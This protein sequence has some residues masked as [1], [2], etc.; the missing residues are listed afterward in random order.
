MPDTDPTDVSDDGERFEDTDN[1]NYPDVPPLAAPPPNFF[2]Q[3]VQLA[4][5]VS[6]STPLPLRTF[7]TGSTAFHLNRR[8]DL[9][10]L[11][12][13]EVAVKFRLPD[14]RAA[15]ADYIRHVQDLR[16]SMFKIGQRRLSR[17]N[18]ELPF[19]HLRVWYSTRVQVQS[20][21]STDV[22]V[23][24]RVCAEPP[25]LEWPFG[26]YDTVLLSDGSAPG[27]GLHGMLSFW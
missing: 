21:D 24:H 14:L 10:P 19:T 8:P 3:A 7:C 25:S 13:D 15:L 5:S 18:T 4:A 23:P 9:A 27:R 1:V 20:I 17:A 2:S 6:P 22:S 26:R 11:T 16:S 12:V